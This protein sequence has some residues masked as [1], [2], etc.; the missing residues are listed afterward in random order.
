MLRY[1]KKYPVS[2]T[3]MLVVVYLSFFRPPSVPKI[4]LFPHAD[5]V[6]H[7]G[8]YFVMSALLWWESWRNH[9]ERIKV[10]HV[11]VGAFLC[12]VLF[13]G[14]I[15]LLQEYCT[16]YRGGDRFDFLANAVGVA[17]ASLIAYYLLRSKIRK[18]AG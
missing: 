6:A 9:K 1:I 11:W 13:S 10:R 17:L 18:G 14:V 2:L 12:P 5:K 8:M 4:A 15:E 3:F 7:M 16:T